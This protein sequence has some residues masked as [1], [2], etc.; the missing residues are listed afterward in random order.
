[1]KTFMI[2]FSTKRKRKLLSTVY[3]IITFLKNIYDIHVHICKERNQMLTVIF[4][5]SEVDT[6]W[7]MGPPTVFVNKV[8]G[9]QP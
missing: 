2:Y 1:M 5:R 7:S 9:T 4:S 6:L 8:T 3:H